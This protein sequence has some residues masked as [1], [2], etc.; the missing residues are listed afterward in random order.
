MFYVHELG[1][2]LTDMGVDCRIEVDIDAYSSA[3]DSAA[4]RTIGS[5]LNYMK[6]VPDPPKFKEIMNNFRPD[7]VLTNSQSYFGLMATRAGK[8]LL[9]H[10]RGDYWTELEWAKETLYTTLQ[11]RLA[12]QWKNKI[13]EKCFEG[14]T[15]ILP[16]CNYLANI[17]KGRYPNKAV[18]VLPLGI[19]PLQWQPDDTTT[20]ELKHP[21]VGLLQNASILGKAKE[22]LVLDDVITSMSDVMFY[23]AGDG[24]YRDQILSV[25]QKHDNFKWLGSLQYPDQV[26]QFLASIDIY[27]LA[28]GIDM[29]PS[30]LLEA[31][32]MQKPIVTTNVGG[33]PELVGQTGLLVERGDVAGWKESL[34][35]LLQDQDRAHRMG[36]AARKFVSDNFSWD[37]I[38]KRCYDILKSL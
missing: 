1:K 14:S 22:M 27:A 8:P 36:M 24:P 2:A 18:D 31:S 30:T 28:T 13:A 32:L 34:S 11:R 19:N 33:V 35:T 10:L 3:P 5:F 4:N 37:I 23:W 9:M 20:M 17:V 7:V 25:L 15:K 29:F 16:V 38:A 6:L 12:L 26:R 21:C